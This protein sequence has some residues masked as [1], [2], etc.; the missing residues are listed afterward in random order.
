MS[1]SCDSWC[2]AGLALLSYIQLRIFPRWLIGLAL[3]E[4]TCH[5]KNPL[6]FASRVTTPVLCGPSSVRCA[7]TPIMTGVSASSLGP[8]SRVSGPK[9]PR[10]FVTYLCEFAP[11]PPS[12]FLLLSSQTKDLLG[13][14]KF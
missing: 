1:V 13:S 10:A 7:A 8:I 12:G 5:L 6:V 9:G 14:F 4:S 2:V 3:D 11:S